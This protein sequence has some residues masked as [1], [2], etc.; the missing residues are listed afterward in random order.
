MPKNATIPHGSVPITAIDDP[1]T[2]RVVMKLN[3]NITSLQ[4]QVK[5]MESRIKKLERLGG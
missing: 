5:A 2:R 4:K 3:E 1:S